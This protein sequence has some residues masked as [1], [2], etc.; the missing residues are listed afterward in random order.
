[1]D[2]ILFA[3][4]RPFG[5]PNQGAGSVNFVVA[6]I[7]CGLGVVGLALLIWMLVTWSSCLNRIR[8]RNRKMEPGQVWL[9]LIPCFNLVWLILTILKV[10]DSLRNEYED[11][12]LRGDDDFGRTMGIVY[13]I[14]LLVC[15]PIGWIFLLIY[16][17]KIAAYT[18]KLAGGGRER[19]DDD[20][21]DRPPRRRRDEDDED[22]DRP[23]RRRRDDDYDDR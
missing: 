13:Y 6:L 23:R 7:E 11:R 10:S 9:N 12:G 15:G 3:Q 4:Q 2:L 16:R 14:T 19:D 1:M 21:E 8:P 20:E 5:G 17:G 22:D 18:R